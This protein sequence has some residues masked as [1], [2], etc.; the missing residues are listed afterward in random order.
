M[1]EVPV[2]CDQAIRLVCSSLFADKLEHFAAQT[3]TDTESESETE[4]Y[5]SHEKDGVLFWQINISDWNKVETNHLYIT[6][7]SIEHVSWET[8]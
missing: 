1:A 7:R 5:R 8:L 2:T 3:Q 4:M 6:I